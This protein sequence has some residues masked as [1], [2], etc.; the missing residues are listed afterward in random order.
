MGCEKSLST[1]EIF[2]A[3]SNPLRLNMVKLLA[4]SDQMN[5]TEI[6]KNLNIKQAIASHQLNIL[7]NKNILHSERIGKKTFYS[8]KHR[9]IIEAIDLV[10]SV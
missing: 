7:R 9:Q 10:M 6:Y 8:L 1:A 4:T 3:L 5:V 2:K